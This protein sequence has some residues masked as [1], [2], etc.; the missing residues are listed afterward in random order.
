[1]QFTQVVSRATTSKSGLKLGGHDD[2]PPVMEATQW[3]LNL[4]S[5]RDWSFQGQPNPHI[6]GRSIPFSMGK[7]LGGGSS[8]NVVAWARGHKSD[9]DFLLRKLAI[10]HGTMNEY[11]DFPHG[12][13]EP[14]QRIHE[15]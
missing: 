6:N 5:E 12:I 14:D 13:R 4:G 7:V 11:A 2:V 10:P 3:P 9:W 1:M 8:I 15:A